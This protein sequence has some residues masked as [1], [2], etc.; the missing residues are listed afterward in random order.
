[1]KTLKNSIQKINNQITNLES[2]L[3]L[4]GDQ[5]QTNRAKT[6]KAYKS[7]VSNLVN[8]IFP[9]ITEITGHGDYLHAKA[10]GKEIFDIN[11]KHDYDWKTNK[12]SSNYLAVNYYTSGA[13]NPKDKKDIE[14]K[15][16]PLL[17]KFIEAVA[18]GEL[19][20]ILDLYKE[21]NK[22]TEVENNLSKQRRD[23]ENQISELEHEKRELLENTIYTPGLV[24]KTE[25]G[26]LDVSDS[27]GRKSMTAEKV[28]I[29]KHTNSTVTFN[30]YY[31]FG[32]NIYKYT[33][34]KSKSIMHNSLMNT[35]KFQLENA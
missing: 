17:G 11:I 26:H 28:E 22:G 9:E 16:L 19:D 27:H 2:K 8:S 1:M 30:T 23:L 5:Y 18:N 14:S 4:L 33:K 10:F 21:F 6:L 12:R 35:L 15:R 34:T 31:S 25:N 13:F 20:E 29:V 3:N 7:S 32:E 24:L